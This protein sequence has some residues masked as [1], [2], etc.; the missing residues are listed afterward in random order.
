MVEVDF[1]EENDN[2]VIQND[3]R[4]VSKR[5]DKDHQGIGNLNDINL[6]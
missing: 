6:I 4:G 3:P 2:V 5:Q 1:V